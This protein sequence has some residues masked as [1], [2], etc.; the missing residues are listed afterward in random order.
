MLYPSQVGLVALLRALAEG[1]I[2]F[3]V[4]GGGAAVLHG[5]PITTFDLDIMPRSE[6]ANAAALMDLVSRHD[7]FI[8]EPMKRKLLPRQSDFPGR[9]QLTLSTRLGPLDVLCRLHNGR[10][11]EELLEHSTTVSDGELTAPILLAL[12]ERGRG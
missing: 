5:A 1:G 8:I 11:Y 4:V 9:G 12:L 2:D 6:A 7:A 3:I 10:G